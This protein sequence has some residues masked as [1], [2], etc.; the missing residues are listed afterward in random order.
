MK[1][2]L[3]TEFIEDG[4][5]IDLIS[6]GMVA[7]NSKE[8]YLQNLDCDFSKASDWVRRNVLFD[9]P[10]FDIGNWKPK[11][12]SVLSGTPTVWYN[13]AQIQAEVQNFLNR[14][15]PYVAGNPGGE[16]PEFYGWY[17]DYDWVVFCQLWGTM[18][19][20]PKTFPRYC[21]DLKQTCDEKGNPELP[22]Q[23]AGKHNALGDAKWNKQ[24]YD[25][26]L[27]CP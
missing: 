4:K 12:S 3:D 23:E 7:A 5:T 27:G 20:L 26:L 15:S 9:L 6:I 8:L 17:C 13:R 21:R 10:Q 22:K 25:Y 24:V 2:F 18:M 11:P 16:K 1:F 19:D 14:N